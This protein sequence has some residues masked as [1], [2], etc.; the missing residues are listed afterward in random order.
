MQELLNVNTD[1]RNNLRKQLAVT[2]KLRQDDD[3]DHCSA[4]IY[5]SGIYIQLLYLEFFRVINL[6][7][8]NKVIIYIIKCVI[9][10]DEIDYNEHK[11]YSKSRTIELT[12]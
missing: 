9:H 4:F 11:G 3:G 6:G 10:Q 2:Q 8:P 1:N 7:F 5:C 12:G